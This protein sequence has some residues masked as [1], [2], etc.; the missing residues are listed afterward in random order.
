MGRDENLCESSMNVILRLTIFVNRKLPE[1]QFFPFFIILSEK[2]A[3]FWV[4]SCE[5]FDIARI[6]C[7]QDFY[8]LELK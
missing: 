2:R 3:K 4:I 1:R 8:N 7:E 6:W 5:I